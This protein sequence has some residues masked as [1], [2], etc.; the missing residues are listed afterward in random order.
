MIE[1]APFLCTG[2]LSETE[3]ELSDNPGGRLLEVCCASASF[4]EA[5]VHAGADRVELCANLVEG[6]TT[7]TAGEQKAARRR[8]EAPIMSMVRCRGGDFAY[9]D[10][11]VEAMLHDVEVAKNLG[12]DGVVFGALRWDGAIDVALTGRIMDAAF[13]LPMTF[14]RAFDLSRDLAESL[15]DLMRLGVPRVLTSA[16][17]PS[18]LDA[19]DTLEQ[20]V[21][22]AGERMSIMACGGIDPE[23]VARVFQLPGVREVHIGA[24]HFAPSRMSHRVIGVPMGRPHHGD[25]YLLEVVDASKVEAV[26][27]VLLSEVSG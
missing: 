5:A 22:G 25:E 11:E 14:H 4:A 27:R 7:P 21:A 9:S 8:I 20:L 1:Y 23:N 2:T 6:G 19:L 24:S 12:M 17:E 15:D 26:S 18:V 16:G 3:V 13:P 10:I